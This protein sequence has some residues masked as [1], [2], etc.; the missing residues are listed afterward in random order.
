M[1]L[2]LIRSGA[3]RSLL[4]QSR[5]A[6][7]PKLNN[8]WASVRNNPSSKPRLLLSSFA[9]YVSAPSSNLVRL[10]E[11]TEILERFDENTIPEDNDAEGHQEDLETCREDVLDEDVL[12]EDDLEEGATVSRH[13][14]HRGL[15]YSDK[16]A[17]EAV[18]QALRAGNAI[19]LLQAFVEASQY[20]SFLETLPPT[21]YLEI[22]RTIQSQDS[23]SEI[24]TLCRS[25]RI[26][27][28]TK[29]R[30]GMR[31]LTAI[32][33]NYSSLIQ[34]VVKRWRH[35][36]HALGLEDYKVLLDVSRM[37][38]DGDLASF[39]FSSMQAD[40]IQ[41]DKSC[42]NSLFEAQCW[43]DADRPSEAY[44]LRVTPRHLDFRRL[45]HPV[46]QFSSHHTGEK[47]LQEKVVDR[48]RQMV[49]S[50]I[51]ADAKTYS[52]LILAM[53]REGDLEAAEAILN[54][55]WDIDVSQI[56]ADNAGSLLFENR[57]SVESPVYPNKD[58]LFTIAHIYGIN[59]QIPKA[60]RVLD[61][62]SRKYSI[63]IDIATWSQLAE[64]TFVL[65]S[66]RYG[67]DLVKKKDYSTGQLPYTSFENFWSTMTSEPYNVQPTIP[68]YDMRCKAFWRIRKR[69]DMVET[70]RE[71]RREMGELATFYGTGSSVPAE[72]GSRVGR[73]QQAPY[74]MSEKNHRSEIL[75]MTR[76]RNHIM[77]AR[78]LRLV[79][80]RTHR[81]S[82]Q[83]MFCQVPNLLSE[84]K[85]YRSALG[86][87]YTLRTGYLE[88]HDQNEFRH[89]SQPRH[90][91]TITVTISQDTF[92]KV[93]FVQGIDVCREITRKPRTR[94]HR[95]L[96]KYRKNLEL[97]TK[98]LPPEQPIVNRGLKRPT[99]I[100]PWFAK[101]D[102]VDWV[103]PRSSVDGKG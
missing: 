57:L 45:G 36:D 9:S 61:Y 29:G 5:C 30:Y 43:N 93:S 74:V 80:G 21:T 102:V 4:G 88:F 65:S 84:F 18:L 96:A 76:Y 101:Q 41:P 15:G 52:M 71:A 46:H 26:S 60:I 59:N 16:Q 64:W 50:G 100:Y 53:G 83:W 1:L 75:N 13:E 34:T 89:P 78:W 87:A 25:F 3:T 44:K 19:D 94:Q 68:M 82:S 10:Q 11:P 86:T 54:R 40:G 97:E 51:I 35:S 2:P 7:S 20:S 81:Q 42:Y 31:D 66:G 37:T 6:T 70:M 91:E 56:M 17:Q 27:D 67:W 72:Q 49:E 55:I 95:I 24:R 38:Y 8:T 22:L 79:L 73:Q 47:G 32:F 14:H 23:L 33:D 90:N 62:V 58:V 12:E 48:F 99:V 28:T 103:H 39:L 77:M 63:H 92:S 85:D 69:A 98:R